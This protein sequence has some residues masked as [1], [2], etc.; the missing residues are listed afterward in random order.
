MIHHIWGVTGGFDSL[1][2]CALVSFDFS[3][4]F[5]TLSH[6]FVEAVLLT[7]QI[8]PFHIQFI[9]STLVAPYHFCVGWG[10]VK[11]ISFTSRA[12]IGQGDPFSPLLFS[13]CALLFFFC[14]MI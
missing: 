2:K 13:F 11:E 1:H 14:S 9:L 8:P 7:I 6:T 5:P 4:T 12:G 3:N 10:V